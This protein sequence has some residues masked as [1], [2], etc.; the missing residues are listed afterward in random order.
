MNVQNSKNAEDSS[1][2]K[3]DTGSTKPDPEAKDLPR[4]IS[5]AEAAR[6]AKVSETWI[7]KLAAEG[8]FSERKV[9]SGIRISREEFINWLR[10]KE[11]GG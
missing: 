10:H 7:C 11:R 1:H 4:Y 3:S 5:R 6:M 8:C 2:A 9:G